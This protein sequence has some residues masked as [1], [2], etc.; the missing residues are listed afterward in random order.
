MN[1]YCPCSK[2]SFPLSSFIA[3]VTPLTPCILIHT[4]ASVPVNIASPLH[5]H[6][7][8]ILKVRINSFTHGEGESGAD[9][10]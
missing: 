2:V 6:T 9:F 3:L 4:F 10:N 7:P 8:C 1:T 5:S